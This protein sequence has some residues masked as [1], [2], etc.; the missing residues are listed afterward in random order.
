MS[1][2][3]TPFS[4][5]PLR[6]TRAT[7]SCC[8][9]GHVSFIKE[10]AVTEPPTHLQNLLKVLQTRGETIISPGAK[11]GLIPLAIPLSKDSSVGSVTALL[12]WPTAPPGLDMPV[13]EVWRSGVRLIARNVDEYIHRILVEEDAQEMSELYIASAE[14]GEKLYKKG[15]FAESQIDNLDV[16]VLKKA[17]V[18]LFPDVLEKKVLRHFDEGDHVSA[19]VTGEFYT[20]KDLFPGFGRPFVYY[21]N[22][23]QKVGR[24]SEAKEAAREVASIAQWEDEQIEFIR[25]KV[26]DEGRFEDLKKGKDPIQVALDVAAFLLDLASIEGTWSESLHHIAKCYEEAGLKDMSNFILYTDDK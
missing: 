26:S 25:E 10:V 1:S 8:S 2:L 3:F 6:H 11:Q 9:S 23:L 13:V 12:R 24:D 14:A 22:I 20:R 21:A 4:A 19:M 16:Y 15:A 5:L 17:S 7:V 18:G